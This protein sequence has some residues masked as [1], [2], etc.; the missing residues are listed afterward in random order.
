MDDGRALSFRPGALAGESGSGGPPIRRRRRTP[1][2]AASLVNSWLTP[3]DGQPSKLRLTAARRPQRCL[4]WGVARKWR[5]TAVRSSGSPC[6]G[7]RAAPQ[8]RSGAAGDG[9][10]AVPPIWGMELLRLRRSLLFTRAISRP[11][12]AR[13]LSPRAGGSRGAIGPTILSIDVPVAPVAISRILARLSHRRR[14]FEAPRGSP[15]AGPFVS[16]SAPLLRAGSGPASRRSGPA[17]ER[18]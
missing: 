8:R 9:F 11:G 14:A 2:N 1:S 3:A 6:P 15:C 16:D 17:S 10:R 5:H 7:W 13:R 18:Q 12:S 4:Y